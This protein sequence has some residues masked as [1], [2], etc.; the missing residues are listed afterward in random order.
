MSGKTT[1]CDLLRD[2]TGTL[3]LP[4]SPRPR[5]LALSSLPLLPY[6]TLST[7]TLGIFPEP[8]CPNCPLP[9]VVK[10]SSLQSN[11]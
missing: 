7:L 1:W 9:L 8:P 11:F 3:F 5:P 6:S 4:L 10:A 2:I